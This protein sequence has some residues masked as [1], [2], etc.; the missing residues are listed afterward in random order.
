MSYPNFRT[1]WREESAKNVRDL[2]PDVWKL[3][4]FDKKPIGV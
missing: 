3:K 2:L 4:K 1:S